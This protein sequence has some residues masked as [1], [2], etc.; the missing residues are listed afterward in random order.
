MKTYPN[1][2][3]S[4]ICSILMQV[5]EGIAAACGY[6]LVVSDMIYSL[7]S[8]GGERHCW[9]RGDKRP[10]YIAIREQGTE[11]GYKEE[12]IERC[13]GL[14]YPL[15]IAKVEMDEVCDYNMTIMFTHNWMNGDNNY[16]EGEFD[17][18]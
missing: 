15:V 1:K 8:L 18:L 9:R 7:S 16:L 4:Q 14:C 3:F 12:C 11:S 5:A 10:F 2:N 17:S 6:N 13:K